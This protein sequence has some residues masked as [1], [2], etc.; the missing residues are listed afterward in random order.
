MTQREVGGLELLGITHC[1]DAH[2]EEHWIFVN[3]WC[4]IQRFSASIHSTGNEP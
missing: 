1:L 4:G 2:D 3:A